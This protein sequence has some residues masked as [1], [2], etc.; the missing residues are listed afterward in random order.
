MSRWITEELDFIWFLVSRAHELGVVTGVNHN[1]WASRFVVKRLVAEIVKLAINHELPFISEFSCNQVCP[2]WWVLA[3]GQC[4]GV[5]GVT[6]GPRQ[7]RPV[8]LFLCFLSPPPESRRPC[9][10]GD[11][12]AE[13]GWAICIFPSVSEKWNFIVLS[14]WDF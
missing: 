1:L 12:A 6:A 9:V 3:I 11:A 7:F 5:T 10:Q 4:E 14:H 8:C 2:V 13:E